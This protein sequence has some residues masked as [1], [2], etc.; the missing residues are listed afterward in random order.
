MDSIFDEEVDEVGGEIEAYCPSS[1]CKCDATHTIVS[2]YEDEVRRVQCIVCREVHAYRKPRGESYDEPLE[3]PLRSKLTRKP[4]WNEAMAKVSEQDLAKCRPYS[5]RDTYE[6]LDIVSHPTFGVGFVTELLPDN[7]VEITFKD[8]QRILVHNRGDLAFKMPTISEMPVPRDDAKRQRKKKRRSPSALAQR[9]G[10]AGGSGKG[11][12][13]RGGVDSQ[14]NGTLSNPEVIAMIRAKRLGKDSLSPTPEQIAAQRAEAEAKAELAKQAAMQ[15]TARHKDN[16][17]KPSKSRSRS[18]KSARANAA[19]SADELAGQQPASDGTAAT[20]PPSADAAAAQAPADGAR[21]GTKKSRKKRSRPA[22][23][24]ASPPSTT[25]D[26]SAAAPPA[27][28]ELAAVPASDAT[29]QSDAASASSHP[30]GGKKPAKKSAGAKKDRGKKSAKAK[31]RAGVEDATEA[32]EL[33]APDQSSTGDGAQAAVE[34]AGA[35]EQSAAQKSAAQKSATQ[36][37]A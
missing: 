32:A 30:D 15:K 11:A 17:V 34:Q 19:S 27:D 24:D 31:G 21:S 33:T 6:E 28:A 10:V 8:E 13:A 22:A 37:S 36:K 3:P 26:D 35:A 16:G 18:R 5:I 4:T 14:A 12:S 7:K 29:G 25:A 23:A 9:M 2:M 1:R 20:A